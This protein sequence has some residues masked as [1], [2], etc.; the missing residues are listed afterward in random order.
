MRVIN[1]TIAILLLCGIAGFCGDTDESINKRKMDSE[2]LYAEID[3][4]ILPN[5]VQNRNYPEI[6]RLAEN[7]CIKHPDSISTLTILHTLEQWRSLNLI[8]SE[9]Y[10]PFAKRLVVYKREDDNGRKFISSIANSYENL[11]TNN[12]T[13]K[14][15]YVPLIKHCQDAVNN[16]KS[17]RKLKYYA[18]FLLAKIY[19]TIEDDTQAEK[20]VDQIIDDAS[21]T[22]F[23]FSNAYMIL[24][25]S[26]RLK[27]KIVSNLVGKE[28]A[29]KVLRDFI[30]LYA[31]NFESVAAAYRNMYE[32]YATF[33]L[34]AVNK[35]P[36]EESANHTRA[37]E[38]LEE[39][40]GKYQDSNAEQLLQ[41]RLNLF[42]LVINKDAVMS[43]LV[44]E[45]RMNLYRKQMIDNANQAESIVQDLIKRCKGTRYEQ[46]AEEA[47]T[48]LEKFKN[49][50]QND[51]SKASKIS[52]QYP[53]L[54]QKSN[55]LGYLLLVFNLIVLVLFFI[56][57]QRKNIIGFFNKK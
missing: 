37:K 49:P 11:Q 4:L 54:P 7:L 2:V 38:I 51:A 35:T 20:F 50:P 6:I 13:D 44:D 43:G 32:I 22:D 48:Y 33:N 14:K 53:P 57:V 52:P 36:E 47:L 21:R 15:L 18:I 26:F 24:D 41:A 1:Y 28:A 10:T 3:N 56:W 29:V 30:D 16:P 42:Y 12:Q 45:E 40:I 23:D 9:Q 17:S 31:K 39:F 8:T 27:S 55:T 5:N 34:S 25:D 19:H 46:A